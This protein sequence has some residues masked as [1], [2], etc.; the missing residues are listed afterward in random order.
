V[1]GVGGQGK[2]HL[3]NCLRLRQVEV[4]AV[5]DA[6]QSALSRIS[7]LGI[8]CYRNYEEMIRQEDLDI[9][10]IALPTHAHRECAIMA[11]ESGSHVFIE[12]P[13]ARSTKETEQ[14]ADAVSRN[15]VRLMVGFNQRFATSCQR[16]KEEIDAGV[17]G[18]IDFASAL[19][20]TGP[21][22]GGHK[23]PEWMF[24]PDYVVGALWD[25]GCHI[26]DL[27]LWYFGEV[28]SVNGRRESLF[29]LG[30]DDYGEVLM[31]FKS[32]VNALAVVSWRARRPCYRIEVAGE[33]GRRVAVNKSLGVFD[34][35]LSRAGLSF[36]RDNLMRKLRGEPFL[37][38]GEEY[39]EELVYFINCIQNHEDPHPNL[40]DWLKVSRVI[41]TVYQETLT[42]SF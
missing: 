4:A 42:N 19:F 2:T 8:K 26:V 6:S 38:M 5:A 3:T 14:I 16:L 32:G 40:D 13:L 27:L 18:R 39:Y 12:K 31:R 20:F 23:V 33:Y 34:V 29:N 17:F 21:F 28:Q 7:A 10:V 22:V 25:S 41:E 24:N 30:Y 11:A 35:G 37:P 15:G 9:V 1:V 36:V